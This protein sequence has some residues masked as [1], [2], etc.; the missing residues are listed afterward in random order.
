MILLIFVVSVALAYTVAQR[1]LYRYVSRRLEETKREHARWIAICLE[2]TKNGCSA[3]AS[4]AADQVVVLR[5]EINRYRR[6][7]ARVGRMNGWRGTAL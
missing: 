3:E 1:P 7:L 4:F 2:L 5:R 6:V